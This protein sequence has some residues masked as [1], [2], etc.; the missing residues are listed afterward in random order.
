MA[1]KKMTG[2]KKPVAKM[3]AKAKPK[4][5]VTKAADKSYRKVESKRLT[6]SNTMSTGRA[7]TTT[8][9]RGST[10]TLQ[11]GND[12][13]RENYNA[14]RG[15]KDDK[16]SQKR[17]RGGGYYDDTATPSERMNTKWKPSATRGRGSKIAANDKMAYYEGGR[18]L[19]A[20]RAGGKQN[21]SKYEK[22]AK[23]AKAKTAAINARA[24][25]KKSRGSNTATQ[26][27][28]DNQREGYNAM[29]GSN[30]PIGKSKQS[31]ASA[32]TST[33]KAIRTYQRAGG[34]GK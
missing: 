29:R 21:L 15:S 26:V 4:A 19:E 9:S 11:V 13:Q 3:V 25:A 22:D 6:K 34:K 16:E 17:V 7:K 14:F 32:K 24:R 28:N 8:K 23:A 31:K 33:Q 30:A 2:A 12:N 1:M 27:G 20:Q 5:A 10:R 18:I